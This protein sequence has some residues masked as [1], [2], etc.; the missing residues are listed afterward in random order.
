MHKIVVNCETGEQLIVQLSENEIAEMRLSE[1]ADMPTSD[2]NKAEAKR[3]LN[4]TDWVNQPDVYDSMNSPQLLNRKIFLEYRS[5]IRAIAINPI[6]GSLNW[7]EA[8]IAIWSV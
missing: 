8:P 6:A 5:Q 2:Q 7:P 3:R 1:L 4:M